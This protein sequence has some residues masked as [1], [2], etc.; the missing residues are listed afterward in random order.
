MH[1]FFSSANNIYFSTTTFLFLFL[2]YHIFI[3]ISWSI[4]PNSIIY[5]HFSTINFHFWNISFFF[6]TNYFSNLDSQFLKFYAGL[7]I[8][9]SQYTFVRFGLPCY[10]LKKH[11]LAVVLSS[12]ADLLANISFKGHLKVVWDYESLI[13]WLYST[14]EKY[15]L[16][17]CVAYNVTLYIFP[18]LI[19]CSTGYL[20]IK[21]THF[22]SQSTFPTVKKRVKKTW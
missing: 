5:F 1:D 13:L 20:D 11:N 15:W 4:S 21:K 9:K 17:D 8:P 3:F 2:D 14:F 7:S 19:I 22:L 10:A 16:T 6:S 12:T 18:Y